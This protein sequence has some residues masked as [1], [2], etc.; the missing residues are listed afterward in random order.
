MM[1]RDALVAQL[2][3]YDVDM[4][5]DGTR[6]FPSPGLREHPQGAVVLFEDVRKALAALVS[7]AQE[8]PKEEDTRE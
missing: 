2:P 6:P 1:P 7:S 5:D 8:A 4:I 3:R